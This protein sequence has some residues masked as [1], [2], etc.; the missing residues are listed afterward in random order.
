MN[1]RCTLAAERH[2]KS[3]DEVAV[4]RA[5]DRQAARFEQRMERAFVAGL[6]EQEA[7]VLRR[8]ERFN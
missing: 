1:C 8:L 5:F 3:M 2:G 7:A 4:W 6:R